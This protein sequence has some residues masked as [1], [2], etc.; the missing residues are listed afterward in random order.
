MAS[1]GLAVDPAS[2]RVQRHLEGERFLTVVFESVVLS[3]TGRKWQ[4]RI[5]PVQRLCPAAGLCPRRAGINR[6]ASS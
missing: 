2:V 6:L 3:A 1:S 5:K 4:H